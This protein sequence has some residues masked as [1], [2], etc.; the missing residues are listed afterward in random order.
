MQRFLERFGDPTDPT[1]LHI[2]RY[3]GKALP[4]QLGRLTKLTNVSISECYLL[5]KVESLSILTNLTKISIEFCPLLE[6]PESFGNLA[7]LETL[8]IYSCYFLPRLPKSFGNLAML[9]KLLGN[10]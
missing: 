3:R 7:A 1:T 10:Q 4:K 2:K 6:L 5:E 8:E 9:I